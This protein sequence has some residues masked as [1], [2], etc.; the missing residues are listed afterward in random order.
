MYLMKDETSLVVDTE[1]NR[2]NISMCTENT[3]F[4]AII[5][6]SAITNY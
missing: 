2:Q 1:T 5:K 3:V 6:G 4:I